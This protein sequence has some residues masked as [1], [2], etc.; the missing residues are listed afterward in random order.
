M[1]PSYSNRRRTALG[2][3]DPSNHN[4]LPTGIPGLASA[5]KKPNQYTNQYMQPPPTAQ[6]PSVSG[7]RMSL[8]P[9]RP[10]RPNNGGDVVMGGMGMPQSIQQANYP[11]PGTVQAQRMGDRLP[12]G[13]G[14]RQSGYGM[15]PAR[16]TGYG[17][18]PGQRRTS[19][20]NTRP[21]NIG[22]MA[23]GASTQGGLAKDPRNI[24]D[25]SFQH[26]CIRT[27]ITY[28][29]GKGYPQP[30]GTKTL[31]APTSKDFQSIFKFLYAKLDPGYSFQKKFEEEVPALL[32]G[33]RYPFADQIS[34]S[35]LYAVG[36]MHSW[37]SLLAM[38]T[39][40]VELL[41]GIEKLEDSEFEAEIPEDAPNHA[42][43]AFFHY[44]TQAYSVFLAGADDFEPMEAELA[45][46]FDRKNVYTQQ[47]I[48]RL[49]KENALLEQELAALGGTESPL[50]TL[51]KERKTLHSDKEKFIQY[52]QHIE[53]KRQ[54]LVDFNAKI[55]EEFQIKGFLIFILLYFFFPRIIN[56]SIRL[57]YP[58]TEVELEKL[59]QE[60]A[61]LQVQVDAQ[62]ISPADVDRMTAEREQLAK[63][64]EAIQSK[65]DEI[66]RHFWEKEIAWQKK[67][68]VVGI[69]LVEKAIQDYNTLAYRIGLIPS[70]SPYAQG[71]NFEIE[72]SPHATRPEHMIS[73]D[74]RNVIKP[75]LQ[76]L[77]KEFNAQFHHSQDESFQLQE[78]FDRLLEQV[79]EKTEELGMMEARIQN[80]TEQYNTEKEVITAENTA[81]NIETEKHERE[82]QRVRMEG[83]TDWFN[84]QQK[85]QKVTIEYD[86]LLRKSNELKEQAG[87]EII[88]ILE[89]LIDFKSHVEKSLA[90]LYKL[91]EEEYRSTVNNA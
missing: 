8:G 42:E 20:Y 66:Q 55:G 64:L 12:Q 58:P 26:D 9:S 73:V 43:K 87:K 16:Q 50:I 86:Q 23:L 28:L 34:K 37:P 39:W 27:I 40:M 24:R 88:R 31:Q 36:S 75:S 91:A 41:M 61:Q 46:S 89:E 82:L 29:A 56:S 81:S 72:F 7:P 44:L 4:H 47:E 48:E 60:K 15:T 70:T 57:F 17:M 63:N 49:T 85:V 45:A 5:I 3:I 62:E 14:G 80:L 32:K 59:N 2:V 77:R 83:Q 13:N 11:P 22:L 52:I 67:H 68:D 54:K 38:L 84:S 6:R 33:L 78:Q 90:E 51:E 71:V 21:S 18:T 53:V 10:I 76:N 35:Q 69:L 1:D 19:T 65:I 25:K 74:L 30:V 79:A